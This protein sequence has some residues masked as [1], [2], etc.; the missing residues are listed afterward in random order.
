M[1]NVPMDPIVADWLS[2]GP[3]QGS[4][5]GLQRALAA[6][7]RVEQRPGWSFPRRWLP[8]RLAEAQLAVPVP[9]GLMLILLLTLLLMIGLAAARVATRP[10]PWRLLM[11]PSAEAL[12]AFQDGHSIH[13][14][15]VDGSDRRQ[16]SRGVAYA[17]S[18]VFSPDGTRVAFISLAA[19][20]AIEGQ[21]LVAPIDGTSAVL[22]VAAGIAVPAAP[23]GSV[24]WSPDGRQI[25]LAGRQG[26]GTTTIFV[27]AA[28][29]SEVTA[30]TDQRM[31]RDLPSW[32]PDGEWV[33]Y[34]AVEPDGM[35][36]HLE[37]IR[38]DGSE[39]EQVTTVI[40]TD[41][42]LSRL[43]WS[44]ANDSLLYL[45]NVGFGTQTKV[46]I[47]LR[48]GHTVEP[49]S[50]GVGGNFDAGASFSPDG[51][52]LAFLTP[53]DG[54]VVADY[55]PDSPGYDGQ[56]R[57]LGPVV[58]CWVGWSPDGTALYGGSPDGCTS[59]VVIP[60]ADPDSAVS[61]PMSGI[62]SWQPLAP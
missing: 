4:K 55:D 22:E 1:N 7:R 34:R 41:A 57:R 39:V 11:G 40:A 32:S 60:L 43:D 15:R 26:G 62:A 51:Q 24:S 48:F 16:L 3:T 37:L 14:A 56:L 49:W 13:A 28:D 59:V 54:L 27:A 12:I 20:D 47:D 58:D 10:P 44:P 18:P 17:A 19:P 36:R 5:Q 61:L 38:P 50:D 31:D 53:D 30:L 46:V 42:D 9:A 45:M 25:A 21:L 2:E 23:P 8:R 35:R 6:A 52:L 29:G 33:A